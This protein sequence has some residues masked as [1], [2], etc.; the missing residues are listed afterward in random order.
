[1]IFIQGNGND[2]DYPASAMRSPIWALFTGINTS[3]V[4]RVE[5][6]ITYEF[7]P[8]MAFEPWAPL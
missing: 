3:D 2:G 5:I 4:Y 1:M 8:T 7:I 6:A